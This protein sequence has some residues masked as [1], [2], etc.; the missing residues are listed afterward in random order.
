MKGNIKRVAKVAAALAFAAPSQ[1]YD[2]AILAMSAADGPM[3]APE[4]KPLIRRAVAGIRHSE[5]ELDGLTELAANAAS[6]SS[7]VAIRDTCSRIR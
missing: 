3:P 1:A 2:G 5:A 7:R 4:L 6:R